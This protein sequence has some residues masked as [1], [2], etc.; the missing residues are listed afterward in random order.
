MFDHICI[1]G[2]RNDLT[3]KLPVGWDSYDNFG[4]EVREQEV[5]GTA[6]VM[7]KLLLMQGWE[8]AVG[9]TLLV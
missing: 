9:T 5:K 7:E 3:Q 2:Q 1:W 8:Y 6:D 4:A